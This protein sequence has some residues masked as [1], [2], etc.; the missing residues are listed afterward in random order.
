V[1][2]LSLL[3][4][5]FLL[6]TG[7]LRSNAAPPAADD[8]PASARI[9]I[10]ELGPTL[11]PFQ[12]VRFCQRYPSDCQPSLQADALVELDSK[13]AG[14]LYRINRQINAAIVPTRKD[15]ALDVG[16]AW[17]IAPNSGDCNDYAVTKQHELLHYRLP[18]S[19]LRLSEVKTM[20]GEGHLV[21]VVSTTKGEL[22]LDNLTDEIRSWK[23][24]D[25]RWLKIQ[26]KTDPHYWVEM[27]SPIIVPAAIREVFRK[28]AAEAQKIGKPAFQKELARR[29]AD[30]DRRAN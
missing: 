18:A 9:S 26:S 21:L 3:V 14:L 24:V 5:L 22:V 4:C 1:I 17:A 16:A 13:T 10:I 15:F 30:S 6:A 11:S 27:R 12:H 8:I 20:D 2:R 29:F 28:I 23:E 7:P 25:Y 19:A